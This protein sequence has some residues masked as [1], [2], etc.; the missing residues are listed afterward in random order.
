MKILPLLT[1][2]IFFSC[3][4]LSEHIEQQVDKEVETSKQYMD[5]EAD[6]SKNNFLILVRAAKK[7]Q[8]DHSEQQQ[9]HELETIITG[10]DNFLDS[11]KTEMDK[12]DE[13]DVRNMELVKSTFLYKS[14]G[15]SII[16]KLTRSIAIA[17]TIAKTEKQKAAIKALSD[18][19]GIQPNPEKWKEQTF[20]LNN[21]LGASMILYG[22]RMEL[23]T[24][25]T[26][27]LTDK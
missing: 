26:K 14:I 11:L 6:K 27:S 1:I 3:N 7:S 17:Q 22:L 16:S 21:S 12:L 19:L 4:N 18:T 13:L 9:L 15:D 20:G 8:N 2:T 5:A 25:G 23:F 10:T 24:I